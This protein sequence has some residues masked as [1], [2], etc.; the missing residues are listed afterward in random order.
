MLLSN[1]DG[2]GLG[3]PLPELCRQAGRRQALRSLE[4]GGVVVTLRTGG[5]Y[6]E[7]RKLI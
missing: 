1:A 6:Q 3:L 4:P 2:I 5:N 7:L